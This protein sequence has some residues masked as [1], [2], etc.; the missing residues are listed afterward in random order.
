MKA[1][2]NG[3]F[4]LVGPAFSRRGFL[5]VAGTGIVATYLTDVLAPAPLQAS[6]S[7]PALRRTANGCVVI[8]LSGGPS[9]IDTWDLKEGPW[10]PQQL[11]PESYGGIRFPRGL[12]PRTAEQ[13]NKITIVRS[14]QAWAAVHALAQAWMQI[15]R[16]PASRTGAIAPHLGA[17]VALEAQLS[18]RPG[19][20]LPG[21]VELTTGSVP[22]VVPD[23]G[24]LPG[25]YGPFSISAAPSGLAEMVHPDGNERFADRMKV[26]SLIGANGA[27][28]AFGRRGSDMEAFFARARELT[29]STQVNALFA[30]ASEAHDRYG[31]SEFG[32]ALLIARNLVAAKKGTRLVQVTMSD[33]DHH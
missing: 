20:I 3:S 8:F 15:A 26:L 23:A 4:P 17:V 7:A 12:M 9:Q 14:A 24:Y 21:F 30:I 18:R 10:T 19:D 25:E 33:W 1:P 5:R 27:T 32:D 6:V 16:N 22:C 2:R 11:T 29:N 13:L 31:R 28:D